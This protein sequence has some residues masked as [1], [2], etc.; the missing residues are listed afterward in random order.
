ME[1]IVSF[2]LGLLV[3]SGQ[4]ELDGALPWAFDLRIVLFSAL[5]ARSPW[6]RASGRLLGFLL[7][8][9]AQSVLPLGYWLLAG[10][11]SATLV[12]PLRDLLFVN[13]A[14]VQTLLVLP[15]MLA[16]ALARWLLWL[17]QSTPLPPWSWTLAGMTMATMLLSPFAHLVLEMLA[18]LFPPG[19]V[20]VEA[21]GGQAHREVFR[22]DEP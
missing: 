17:A 9:A 21:G 18:R 20:I 3:A 12:L 1:W 5:I 8:L 6:R 16:F 15:V 14:V 7:G 2:F 4:R 11:L 10:G 22:S 19:V 13:H